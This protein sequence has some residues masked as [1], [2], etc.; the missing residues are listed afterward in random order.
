MI[1][2]SPAG[3]SPRSVAA[4]SRDAAF[5][6]LLR[7]TCEAAQLEF[8]VVWSAQSVVELLRHAAASPPDLIVMDGQSLGHELLAVLAEVHVLAPTAV[9]LLVGA[10]D[11][12]REIARALSFGLR[13]VIP[14]ARLDTD[15]L[16]A[17]RAIGGNELW[18]SRALTAALLA[19]R[20][21]A[22]P[23]S[24]A[25]TWRNLPALTA[26]ELAVLH[27]VLHGHTNK[28]IARTL[29]I[30][31]QTVKIHLQNIFHKLRVHR[32]VDLMMLHMAAQ[33]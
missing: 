31:E 17:A 21:Q 30:S 28:E 6:D 5:L 16:P 2:G 23:E 14:H 3:N 8:S 24:A 32:R 22:Q 33:E 27:E 20:L 25:Q 9:S 7:R 26:R 15:L 1:G 13:G 12:A 18:L 10:P 19:D 11:D 29:S 4:F